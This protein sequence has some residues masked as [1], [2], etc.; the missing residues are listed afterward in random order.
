[1]ADKPT[2]ISTPLHRYRT[3]RLWNINANIVLADLVSTSATAG[4]MQAIQH[5]LP[6]AMAIVIGTAIIDGSVSLAV[7]ASLHTLTN[8]DRGVNDL[9]RVQVHRWVLSPL[10]YVVGAGLQFALLAT[11]V[12]IGIGVLVAYLSAV[13]VVRT[14]HTVYGKRSGLF[15]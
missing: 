13:A 1:M 2:Q 15:H 7:F 3:N 6:T 12:G 4:V 11:G 10:H 8:R 14:V 9:F 5:R